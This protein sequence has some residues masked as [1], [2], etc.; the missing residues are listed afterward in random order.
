[1]ASAPETTDSKDFTTCSEDMIRNAVAGTKASVR[2]RGPRAELA[3]TDRLLSRL[4]EL[5][6]EDRGDRKPPREVRAEL[7]EIGPLLSPD[8][9]ARLERGQTVQECLD[10]LFDA[11][12]ELLA[13]CAWAARVEAG[14]EMPP[15][16]RA[17]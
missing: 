13:A 1:M 11:Q 9:R 2:R 4:E 12:E 6:L 8:A 7:E 15:L 16:A 14:W 5:N 10:A 3:Q 17:S